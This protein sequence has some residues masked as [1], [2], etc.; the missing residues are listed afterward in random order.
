[1]TPGLQSHQVDVAAAI[2][3]NAGHLLA[4]DD[5]AQLGTA[6]V[7]LG[8]G[9]RDVHGLADRADHQ[10][11]VGPV[12]LVDQERD[13]G[14][15]RFTEPL[16]LDLK[17]V[18]VSHRNAQELVGAGGVRLNVTVESSIGILKGHGRI[19][20][21]GAARVSHGTLDSSRDFSMQHGATQENH[22]GQI[23]KSFA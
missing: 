12:L 14:L 21:D 2:Q 18:F 13:T 10:N 11:E 20:H 6:G 7:H 17:D 3:G 5:V 4:L 1:M 8:R 23:R 9:S 15:N 19:R 16:G 22:Y